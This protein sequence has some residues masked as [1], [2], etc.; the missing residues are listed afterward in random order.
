MAK[1]NLLKISEPQMGYT[2]DF[3]ASRV[4][5]KPFIKWA[6]GKSRLLADMAKLFP[7]KAQIGRY[8]EP[9]LLRKHIAFSHHI[10]TTIVFG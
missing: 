3:N 10:F 8:F 5:A 4:K 2:L 6:G 9:F 7:P 1:N